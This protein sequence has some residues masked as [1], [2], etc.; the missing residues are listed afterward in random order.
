MVEVGFFYDVA[1]LSPPFWTLRQLLPHILE[2]V[3]FESVCFAAFAQL[4]SEFSKMEGYSFEMSARRRAVYNP[5]KKTGF[6]PEKESQIFVS[7]IPEDAGVLDLLYFFQQTGDLFQ[8][9]LVMRY[10]S[11]LNRGYAFIT[12]VNQNG[13]QRAFT[14][15]QNQPFMGAATLTIKLTTNNRRIF[16]GGLPIQKTKDNIWQELRGGYRVQNIVDVITYRNHANPLFNRGF[17]FLEFRTHEEAS[18]F[19][20]N[21]QDCL[22]LFGRRVLVD[23][24]VP[25]EGEEVGEEQE[26]ASAKLPEKACISCS[27]RILLINLL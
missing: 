21:F 14:E 13:A 17:V 22:H 19:R 15:L 12:Y 6:R 27:I 25:L 8:A 2:L 11:E 18:Q 26:V 1:P 20:D 16:I 23:W 7:D 10:K 24:S 5:L 3:C 4:K 9:T